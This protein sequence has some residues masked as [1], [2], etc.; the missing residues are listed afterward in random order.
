MSDLGICVVQSGSERRA[1][2]DIERAGFGTRVPSFR[3]TIG[4]QPARIRSLFPGMVFTYLTPGYGDLNEIEGVR[5]LTNNQG[6]LRLVGADAKRLDEIERDCLFGNHNR[7]KAR[8]SAGRFVSSAI[9][10]DKPKQKKRRRRSLF[11]AKSRR[12]E[13][14][15]RYRAKARLLSNHTGPTNQV[16]A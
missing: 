12:A 15:S 13:R 3:V 1:Q 9:A 2:R 5:V 14:R 10:V 7:V 4:N 16:S 6:P 11:A 8:N